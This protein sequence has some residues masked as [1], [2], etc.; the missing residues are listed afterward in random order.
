MNRSTGA[1]HRGAY[2]RPDPLSP[3]PVVRAFAGDLHVVH[4][5]FLQP[6]AGDAH[7]LAAAAHL[8]D[9]GVASVAHRGAQAP[10]HL[11][12]HRCDRPLVGH[13]PLDPLGHQL[14]GGRIL[15]EV[16]VGRAARHRAEA[17]HAAIGL[18]RPALVK[19]HLAR[20]L[21]GA[22]DRRAD[23]G[24]AC[25]RRDRLRE[26]ARE[27]D[28][29]IGD[30]RH[31][32]RARAGVHDRGELR[33][34][35]A[36]DDARGADRARADADLDR[37]RTRLDQRLRR[38]RRRHVAGHH[39]HVL[40][41][42][43]DPLDGDGDAR[44]MA[45]RGVDHDQVAAGIDERAA[46]LV[47]RIAHGRGGGSAQPA[48]AVLRRERMQ[49]RLLAVLQ[50]QQPGQLALPVG[51][52]K[53]LDPARLHQVH[54]LFAV[55]RLVQDREVVARHHRRDR[56]AV[57]GGKAHV[58]VGDDAH[59]L[60]RGIDH[61][62]ARDIVARDQRLRIGERL[63]RGERDRIVDDAAFETLHPADL[64]GLLRDG[65]VAVDHPHA[66]RLRQ[67][68]G[69]RC[70]GHGIHGGGQERNVQPDRLRHE[71]RNIGLRRQDR[72]SGGN[73]KNIVE[74]ERLAN[75]HRNLLGRLR[76][77]RP[78][79]T[80]RCRMQAPSGDGGV[81]FDRKRPLCPELG[82][83]QRD[84]HDDDGGRH[85]QHRPGQRPG[86]AKRQPEVRGRGERESQRPP[87]RAEAGSQ[88]PARPDHEEREQEDAQRG[89]DERHALGI[90]PGRHVAKQRGGG[91]V[92]RQQRAQGRRHAFA[93]ELPDREAPDRQRDDKRPPE[94]AKRQRGKAEPL[95]GE[96]GNDPAGEG[97]MPDRVHPALLGRT[98]GKGPEHRGGEREMGHDAE[99]QDRP[100][101]GGRERREDERQQVEAEHRRREPGTAGQDPQILE[102]HGRAAH[103]FHH[104][105]QQREEREQRHRAEEQ[106]RQ[107]RRQREL[108]DAATPAEREA[109][110]AERRRKDRRR[111]APPQPLGRG[112][113]GVEGHAVLARCLCLPVRI[114]A[115]GRAEDCNISPPRKSR[116]DRRR[117]TARPRHA[118]ARAVARMS[119]VVTA[120]GFMASVKR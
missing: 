32:T 23:H 24:A 94:Q 81:G 45:V 65:E 78:C 46:A 119:K 115:G 18:V 88:Q 59:D 34:A 43:L 120:I 106:I 15:L 28:A 22:G 29:A 111:R 71:G 83:L 97:Q 74:G 9:R 48:L 11:V 35:D 44:R 84:R 55:G 26:I 109:Q 72:G 60:A 118:E 39:L 87:E 99:D 80:H 105:G 89:K 67:R 62:E 107:P 1:F 7:E 17:S 21:V 77:A 4:V 16:A 66:A 50:R 57:I 101:L 12:Q 47:A 54:R 113:R 38:P 96:C 8:R 53:L 110:Q 49:H 61:G 70:L 64:F 85:Q 10:H 27:L 93:G 100:G 75:L 90:E 40:A 76:L 104:I 33:H 14:V 79:F 58:A 98:M 117:R 56:R 42:F 37:I 31:V 52:Q 86:A 25:A 63:F 69:H 6:G 13:L 103:Q 112:F 95:R 92:N 36:R 20:R 51:H 68:N 3:D 91:K 30:D 102:H 73:E 116:A 5:A 82:D 41:V 108:P 2:E 19:D 114:L